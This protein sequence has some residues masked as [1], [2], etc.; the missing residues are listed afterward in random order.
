VCVELCK[1]AFIC[2]RCGDYGHRAQHCKSPARCT[3]CAGGHEVR[4]CPNRG[5]LSLRDCIHCPGKG[6][7]ATDLA[8]P[9]YHRA[10]KSMM[11]KFI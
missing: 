11:A 8:C 10:H 6:H 5:R 1:R 3:F 2:Y 9:R 4:A 7:S